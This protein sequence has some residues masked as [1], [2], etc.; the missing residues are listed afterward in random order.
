MKQKNTVRFLLFAAVLLLLDG[1]SNTRYLTGG[2]MLFSGND[3]L[4]VNDLTQRKDVKAA[5]KIANDVTFFKP[6]GAVIGSR[7]ILPPFGLWV[8]NYMK[9]DGTGKVS[10]WFFKTFSSKPVLVSDVNPE[11]RSKK[12]ESELFNNG[13]FKAKVK[14]VLDTCKTNPRKAKIQYYLQLENPYHINRI[15]YATP[16]DEVD[17]LINAYQEKLLIKPGDNFSLETVSSEKNKITSMLVEKGYYYFKA[18]YLQIVADTVT[19]PFLI[20]LLIEKSIETPEFARYKYSIDNIS[21]HLSGVRVDSADRRDSKPDTIFH[22]GIYLSG[23]HNYLKPDVITRSIMFRQGDLYSSSKHQGTILRMNNYGVF[24]SVR[25]QYVLQDSLQHKLNLQIE[26]S[27]VSNVSLNL[28]GFVQTK[29]SGFSGPGVEASLAHAN[30]GGEAN[31]F[32]LKLNGGFEW[33]WG[34]KAQNNLG[35]NSYNA[36]LNSSFVFPRLVVPFNIINDTKLIGS[37]TIISLGYEFMNNMLYYRMSAVKLGWGYQWKRNQKITNI[38]YP[39]NVN[40]VNLLKTTA[41]FDSIVN[42]NPYVK[43]S[44]GEQSIAGLKYDFIYDNMRLKANGIYMQASLSTSGNLIDLVM[45]SFG[46]ERPYTIL[47]NVYSQF[48]KGSLDLRYHTGSVKEGLVFRIFAGTGL[49]YGNSTVMPYIEQFYSGGSNSIRGFIPRSLGPG[50]YKP[51]VN[52]GIIDQTGDV[53]LEGNIEY[54]FPF[55]KMMNGA[56]FVDAGN[57]WLL[58]KD[59]LRSGAEFKFNSFAKQLAV[60]T[61]FGLRFD[62]DFFILRTDLGLP[63]R[64]PYAGENGN[65]L[66]TG[67]IFHGFR[68]NLAIGY[69]F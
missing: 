29:S 37:K 14:F 67:D 48:V 25:M 24:K 40:I 10:N 22:D 17:S 12:V 42:S 69:P 30:L 13:F 20:D 31:K 53:K 62:F 35:A 9:G 51:A 64:T 18:D 8:H 33:Q 68:F 26:S 23:L 11:Q 19:T 54:R 39:F 43:K 4:I 7:R 50:S 36:G 44:F 5:T 66:R 16:V 57:V 6:N 21:F 47:N 61:G 55:S 56:L 52:S 45:R 59:V 41:T 28:E 58:D 2:D 46:G 34:K 3:K 15:S 27:P 60:A 49:S 32:S 38:F 63:L 1:C 65:W